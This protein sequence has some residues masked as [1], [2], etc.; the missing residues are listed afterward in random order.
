MPL[1]GAAV[2]LAA[3]ERGGGDLRDWT[4]GTTIAVLAA[5]AVV[6]AL[7]VAWT[8]R[9]RVLEMILWA[10]VTIAAEVALVF[11]AGFELLDLGPPT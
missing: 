7:I 3:F 2:V 6:A 10:L 4:E 9:P 8:A 5:A 1:L 11:G